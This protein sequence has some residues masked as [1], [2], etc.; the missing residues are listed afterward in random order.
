[1]AKKERIETKRVN[2]Y[3]GHRVTEKDLDTEQ[4]HNNALASNLVVDFHGSGIVQ[5]SPFEERVLL[6]TK[7]PGLYAEN[8]SKLDIESGNYDGKAI[9][10]D[11][12]P[13]DPT[14][15]NRIQ[16]E[17]F[18]SQV[19]GK[20]RT[21]IMVLGRAFD[22]A[23]S[24]GELVAEFVEF[25]ENG[26][27]LS[28]HYYTS[29]IAVLFNNFSGGTG[30]NEVLPE[31]DSLNLI[32]DDG[33]LVIKEAPA[34]TVYPASKTSYQIES[35][36]YDMIHFISSSPI[37]SILT[38]IEIALGSSNNINDLYIELNG[39]GTGA[40]KLRFEKNGASSISYGQKFLSKVNNIQRVDLLL[41]AE[42]DGTA[43]IENRFDFSGDIVVG[44]HELISNTSCITDPVPTD[45]ID[46]DP[47]ITPLVEVSF[48]QSDLEV[49]GYKLSDIPQIVSFNF[50]G[51]LIADPNIDPSIQKGK[52]YAILISRRG[53]NRTGTVILENGYD[54]VSK[55][56]EDGVPLTTLEQFGKTQSKYVEYDPITKRFVG[57]SRASLWYQIHTDAVEVTNGTAYTD[58]GIAVTI[59]KWIGF[60]G[61]TQI[62]NFERDIN[63]RTVS[64]GTSNYLLL[65]Q[66]EMFT[67]P[68]VHPRTNN[69]VFTRISDAPSLSVVNQAELDGILEDTVPVILAKIQDGNTRSATDI[70]GVFD[71][72]GLVGIDSVK[73]IDPGNDILLS[74]LINRIITPDTGCNC[75]ARYRIVKVDCSIEKAGDLNSDGKITANDLSLMLNIVGN[76]INSEATE[77]SI[78]NGDLDIIDFVKSDLNGDGTVDGIDIELLEDGVD[79]YVNFT[80]LEEFRVLTLHLENILSESDYPNIF[81]D[82][83]G[84]GSTTVGSD[85]IEFV[86]SEAEA[87]IIRPGDRVIIPAGD[88]DAGEYIVVTK[89]IDG[90]GSTVTVTVTDLDGVSPEFIGSSGFNVIVNSGTAVN[91]YADNK[92][93][94]SIPFANINY[95]IDFIEA[96][97]QEDF[98]KITDL[99]RFVGTSFIEKDEG[100]CI[101]Q[102]TD[103]LPGEV[104][105]PI[106]KNQ[107]YVPGDLYLPNGNILSSPG[108]PHPGDFE[109]TNIKIP[110]P[111][112]TISGCSLDLY[113]T[114]IKSKDGTCYTPAG[115]PAMKFSDGTL[116]GCEDIG[117]NTD[118][119]KGRVKFGTNISGIC[120]DTLVDGYQVDG[121]CQDGYVNISNTSSA[122]EVISE[123]FV[124]DSYSAFDSWT[125]NVANDT[126]IFTIS[127]ASG[128]NVPAIFELNTSSSSGV[129]FGRLD[130]VG[131]FSGDFIIDYT[132]ARTTWVDSNLVN[133]AV[134]TFST[135][136]VTNVDGSTSTLK[137]GWR[138]VGGYTTKL[139]YSGVIRNSS[140]VVVDTF[141]FEI[142]APDAVGDE[143]AFRLRRINDVI[144][145]YYV[146]PDKL[147]ESTVSSFGQYVRIGSNPTV[148]PGY[149][150]ATISV[151]MSQE[152]SPTINKVFFARLKNLSV[153][154]NY[155]SSTGSDPVTIGTASGFDNRLVVT[156]PFV[157]NSK[158]SVNYAKINLTSQTTGNI[159]DTFIVTPLSVINAD[160]LGE[161]FNIPKDPDNSFVTSFSPGSIT[162]GAVTSIDITAVYKALMS[163]PGHLPGFIRGFIIE[164]EVGTTT[165]FDVL[166]QINIEVEF[167]DSTSG[168]VFKV[169]VDL[170]PSTGIVTFDTKNVLFDALTKTNRTV[171]N[172]GVYLKKS[173]FKNQDI[174]ITIDDLSRL[175]VGT[176]LDASTVPIQEQCYFIA[177]STSVGTFVEG[178]FP[179]IL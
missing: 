118:L 72:P 46:F 66:E 24:Q 127:H 156:L 22:G 7:S 51:T 45:L 99:R 8:P 3:D 41:S 15:G 114:F 163:K 74:N 1:M 25:F 43:P 35:P 164:G 143:V 104:A 138:L 111:P 65:S 102:E 133:G 16:F 82:T 48:S 119:S 132:M 75:N 105:G 80:V 103:C 141:N 154:Y 96:P 21:K 81:T 11:L 108:V 174:E 69:F 78:F 23:S 84:S 61:N 161:I 56:A 47:E 55:K 131:S 79:G 31:V 106:Y 142:N 155:S 100:S 101:C 17:L 178:P 97:F 120:V 26:K 150:N 5:D 177:G 49:L 70:T 85:V 166:K 86:T 44:I 162:T 93:L 122:V 90:Y 68:G 95:S 153:N 40:D 67:E 172:F 63:L 109:Y 77:R 71:K 128:P 147:E 27:K 2:F 28:E 157:L 107:T 38:E 32:G 9:Y 113:N 149:G 18:N 34:M 42:E 159:T 117:F 4:I 73:I 179:C 140:L 110:I 53:D 83:S 88:P 98:I 91:T 144:Y 145:A 62:S 176:C 121:Y 13:S 151:E 116:V 89:T 170:D 12:Q 36:N 6:N 134:S 146:I 64:E 50:A 87:L 167:L 148:Q 54:K 76:T 139:F 59:P 137:L 165:S 33:Y 29:I 14:Y 124:N 175:G 152:N 37:R 126:S 92:A 60:V 10:L 130:K 136:E 135:L 57:D 158:T 169:G 168:I 112:G 19:K 160:N 94:V 115:Y 125:E 123:N 39:K 52:Y 58:S 30:R 129:R 173:G 171:L 20:N